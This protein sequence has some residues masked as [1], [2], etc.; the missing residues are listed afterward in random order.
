MNLRHFFLDRYIL[1]CFYFREVLEKPA[2]Q[3]HPHHLNEI[4]D[5]AVRATTAQYDD[6]NIL[7]RLDAATMGHS[8]NDTGWD[9]FYLR[10]HVDGPIGTVR[11][12]YIL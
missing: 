1:N 4:L 12:S 7:N 10:Y 6:E 2:D 8:R 3:L 11:I 9:V 5:T